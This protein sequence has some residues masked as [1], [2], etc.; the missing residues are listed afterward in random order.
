MARGEI[1]YEMTDPGHVVVDDELTAELEFHLVP[2]GDDTPM[3]VFG[4]VPRRR[5]VALWATHDD[6]CIAEMRG[7]PVVVG[8]SEMSEKASVF[9]AV[10]TVNPWHQRGEGA[11][12]G[13]CNKLAGG[14]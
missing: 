13:R 1:A 5:D 3:F 10:V 11:V 7:A 14:V 9:G 12:H 6:K 4:R 8:P 2:G